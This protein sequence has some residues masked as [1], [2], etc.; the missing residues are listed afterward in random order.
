MRQEIVQWGCCVGIANMQCFKPWPFE[1]ILEQF[2]RSDMID[3]LGFSH[4]TDI[5]NAGLGTTN[6]RAHWARGVR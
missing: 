3:Q 2:D 5:I 4:I 6:P 1:S